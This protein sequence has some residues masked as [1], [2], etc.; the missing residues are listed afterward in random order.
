MERTL[1]NYIRALRGAGAAVSPSEA[2][3]AARALA[4]VGYADRQTL[5]D[6]LGVVLAKTAEEKGIHERLFDLYFRR[7]AGP[8]HAEREHGNEGGEPDADRASGE[9]GGEGGVAVDALLDLAR[10]GDP[11]RMAV[12]M[13][14]A[15]AAAGADQI[16]FASQGSFFA[17]RMLEALGIDELEKRLMERLQMR[18]PDA[19]EAAQALMD[20]RSA[21]TREARKFVDQRF[22][23]F[24]RS[25]TE[26][27]MNTVV[28]NRAIDQL[29]L[30]D[31]ERMKAVVARMAKR[32]AV[33]HSRRRKIRNR[34]QLDIR[35]TLRANAGYDGVPFEV[36]WKQKHR[37]R[38]KIVAVCDVSGSVAA[39][40]RFLL[41]FLYALNETVTDL[42]A[43]AF[44]NQLIDV[45]GPL[46]HLSFEMAM[47]YIV[48]EVGSGGTDYGQA[49]V[50]LRDNHWEQ[51]DRRTTVLV[52]GDGRSNHTNPRLDI[53]AEMADR[54]K[55]VV[56]LCPEPVGRWGSGDSEI[57]R[58]RP[59]C[60][61]LSY[62]AT[63]IDLEE[64]LDEILLAYD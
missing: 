52:L 23:V 30:R 46:K 57:L 39:Y 49:L 18:T 56:W 40:V 35:R 32:L 11:D 38:P 37:D 2:I 25:A 36:V 8:E 22:E 64:A 50:D 44:S 14:R 9:A 60:T 34:G 17:R 45:S 13:E 48:Q 1:T 7:P 29:S 15:G 26:T 16:R 20:A 61:H 43:F 31:M 62:C 12:A 51:I 59:Y 41:M 55:R 24:G 58:Y 54:A 10:S 47:D 6:S 33:K 53:L 3:D 28:A 19:Q 5:K 27:F 21:L 4:L 63:A 42:G